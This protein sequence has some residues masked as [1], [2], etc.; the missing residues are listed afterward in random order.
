MNVPDEINFC[1]TL[2]Y[3]DYLLPVLFLLHTRQEEVMIQEIIII[4]KQKIY[5]LFAPA[6][7][8]RSHDWTR[9]DSRKQHYPTQT[10][11]SPQQ[12][13]KLQVKYRAKK[14]EIWNNNARRARKWWI[15]IWGDKVTSPYNCYTKSS[16][17]WVQDGVMWNVN[18]Y[19][20]GVYCNNNN[21]NVSHLMVHMNWCEKKKPSQGE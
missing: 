5:A 21:N 8:N 6:T 9:T 16:I 1:F 3:T 2:Q 4:K 14:R 18:F 20:C 12:Q 7:N 11:N 10:T 19:I 13:V 15:C 17:D